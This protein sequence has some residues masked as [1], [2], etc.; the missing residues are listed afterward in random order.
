MADAKEVETIHS[1]P[2]DYNEKIDASAAKHNEYPENTARRQSVALNIVEN[3]LKV[4]GCLATSQAFPLQS[5]NHVLT[6]RSASRKNKASPTP[7]HGRRR[8]ACL[9]TSHSSA[10][11][12]WSHETLTGSNILAMLSRLTNA[13]H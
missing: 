5:Q 13:R 1:S 12:P 8:M 7:K 4:C 11:Q 6:L 9:S 3:P 10:G 2:P